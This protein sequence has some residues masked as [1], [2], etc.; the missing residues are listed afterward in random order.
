MNIRTAYFRTIK[1]LLYDIKQLDAR[2]ETARL[3]HRRYF[4]LRTHTT[5]GKKSIRTIFHLRFACNFS[6][7]FAD[8]SLTFC[9]QEATP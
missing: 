8:Q 6:M 9:M 2:K 7:I 3:R 4:S 1:L 5:Y